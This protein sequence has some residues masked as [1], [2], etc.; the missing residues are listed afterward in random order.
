MCVGEGR[1]M[2]VLLS[3]GGLDTQDIDAG[4]SL[5]KGLSIEVAERA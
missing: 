2:K 4:L 1:A 3:R 5:E